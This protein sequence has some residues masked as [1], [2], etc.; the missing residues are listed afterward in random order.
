MGKACTEEANDDAIVCGEK[1]GIQG[2][3]DR[4]GRTGTDDPMG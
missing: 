4:P 1:T 3:G 2:G